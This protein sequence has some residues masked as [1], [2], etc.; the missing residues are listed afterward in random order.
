MG[1]ASLSWD[2]VVFFLFTAGLMSKKE[3]MTF[4]NLSQR[5]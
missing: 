5:E 2:M 1:I 3:E 4:L